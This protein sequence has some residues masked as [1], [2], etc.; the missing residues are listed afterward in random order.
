MLLSKLFVNLPAIP[1]DNNLAEQALRGPVVGRKNYYGSGSIQSAQFTAD[2]F[3]LTVTLKLNNI[4]VEKFLTEYL[5]AC[6]AN[7]GKPPADA[8]KYLPW[9]K[10]P[11]P[12]SG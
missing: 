3:T 11:P 12:K 9:N 6:A 5:T 10:R 2:M 7:G 1:P 4:K 8:S